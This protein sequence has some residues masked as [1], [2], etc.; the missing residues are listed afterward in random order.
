M[1]SIKQTLVIV[2]ALAVSGAG[3]EAWAQ[4]GAGWGGYGVNGIGP[5][6][7]E[8]IG[9][10]LQNSD[11]LGLS[12]EQVA[13]LRTLQAGV[14]QEV[15]P[16][17]AEVEALRAGM[18]T[19][20]VSYATGAGELRT[21]LTELDSVSEPYRQ[22]V[23][24]ILTPDQHLTLQGMMYDTR[25]YPGGWYGRAGPGV[26]VRSWGGTGV[27][28]RPRAGLGRGAAWGGRGGRGRWAGRGGRGAG[29][30]RW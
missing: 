15:A 2:V 26:G 13:G 4:R 27:G 17:E 19:G 6:L 24:E 12:E 21:L 1:S 7:G 23:A 20:E 22:R 11:R 30:W 14:E 25:P 5:R 28:V 10:A 8:N 18:R 29:W 3:S 16:L 9:L